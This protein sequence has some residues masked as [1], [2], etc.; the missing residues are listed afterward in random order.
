MPFVAEEDIPV[1]PVARPAPRAAAGPV[2]P[3]PRPAEA[4]E[5]EPAEPADE[6]PDPDH[7]PHSRP[8]AG[9][10]VS[11]LVGFALVPFAIPLLWRVAPLVT[12][13]EPA[14][15]LAVPVSLAVSASA[16]CLGVVYTIDWTATTRV[17]GVLMLVALAYLS[18]AG[19]FFLKKDLMDRLRGWGDPTRRWAVV[20]LDNGRCRVKMPA[21]S[22]PDAGQPL[23]KVVPMQE[24][25]QATY[26]PEHP[27]PLFR[28]RVAVSAP[29]APPGNPDDAW[30]DRVGA[31]ARQ[32]LG[33][34][35]RVV[36]SE[37]LTRPALGRE[38]LLD[39][40]ENAYRVVRV[41]VIG[42]RVYFLS[43]EGPNLTAAD[44]EYGKPFF[45][46]FVV[47]K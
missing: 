31:A 39:L 20:S 37:P 7:D 2:A 8:V 13:Q 46:D 26:Q 34:K 29:G 33:P 24:G 6:V 10:P 45:D 44:D 19:L 38:W 5:V 16:L 18:A 30:F 40:G 15:S 12:G 9:L 4:Y 27:G 43:A 22:A 41:Y 25:R 36:T 32:D 47:G 23:G 1:V 21:A 3:R 42:D 11:V 17:K 35:V 14:L 28:Y